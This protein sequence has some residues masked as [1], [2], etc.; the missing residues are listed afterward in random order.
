MTQSDQSITHHVR[1]YA[2]PNA[3]LPTLRETLNQR[4]AKAVHR[5][6]TEDSL[7]KLQG[8]DLCRLA[9]I[10][11]SERRGLV[12][13]DHILHCSYRSRR[14][15]SSDLRGIGF[16]HHRRI[17]AFRRAAQSPV[18]SRARVTASGRKLPL[19]SAVSTLSER[20]L[21]VKADIEC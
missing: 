18:A 14:A 15:S 5:P 9:T 17:P 10:R 6:I 11:N 3:Q 20:P 16:N 4:L 8:A 1:Q 2:L 13:T 21:L 12:V 7:P 19:I